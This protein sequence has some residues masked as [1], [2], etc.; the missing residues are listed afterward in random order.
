MNINAYLNRIQYTGSLEPTLATLQNLHYQHLLTVPLENLDIHQSRPIRL[1]PNELF[2][3]LITQ[4]RGGFCYELNGLFY[5]LLRALGF[6]VKQISGRVFEPGR[7]FKNEFDHLAIVAHIN[8]VD[9]LVDVGFGRRFSLYPMPIVFN[10][11]W[12][13]RS[14][15]YRVIEHDSD[16][17]AI[18]QWDKVDG[19]V[20]AYIF[21]L[22]LRELSDFTEMCHYHQT[23]P[24]SFF[25]RNKVCTVVTTQGRITLTDD[26]LK[27]TAYDKSTELPVPDKQTFDFFLSLYF[28]INLEHDQVK[29]RAC[30]KRLEA[31][32]SDCCLKC[33][34]VRAKALAVH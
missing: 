14:G 11:I 7:G 25:T 16:Y 21:T 10:A 24:D 30:P 19:W 8:G 29:K 32:V 28:G 4:K 12:E 5:E 33:R 17:R 2:T 3:K 34:A 22:T 31:G 23:S 15:R 27:I 9:W 18:Q 1:E 26:R 13:D 6:Q 20:T